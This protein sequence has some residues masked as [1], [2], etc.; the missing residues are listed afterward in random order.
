MRSDLIQEIDQLDQALV[1]L[2][3]RLQRV[4]TAL[5]LTLDARRAVGERLALVPGHAPP[6]GVDLALLEMS[7]ARCHELVKVLGSA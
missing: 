2:G 5:A 4:L 6:S 1:L 3:D 7:S